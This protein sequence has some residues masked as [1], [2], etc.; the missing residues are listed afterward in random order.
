MSKK[1]IILITILILIIIL[2]L[3][4][5]YLTKNN[6]I[7]NQNT[8]NT[9][10]NFFADIFNFG[11]KTNLNQSNPINNLIDFITGNESVDE[12]KKEIKL[13]SKIS[14]LPIAG[15]GIYQK[16]V[17]TEIPDVEPNQI[18]QA[19]IQE[20][21]S[22]PNTE[23]ISVLKYA[24]KENG[25]IYQTYI[26][27]FE[28]KIYSNT[29]IPNP[30][31]T[32][33]TKYNVIYRY[34]KNKNT[35]VTFLGDLPKETLGQDSNN[36]EIFGSFLQDGVKEISISKDGEKIFYLS[37]TK[38]GVSGVIINNKNE[39]NVIFNSSFSEWNSYWPNNDF[40]VLNTRASGLVDGFAY[41]LNIK[42]S[43]FNK[44]LGD[45]KGLTTLIN[46]DLN[47]IL[48][49][50]NNLSMKILNINNNEVKNLRLRTHTEKCVWSNDNV[51]L[52]C[53]IPKE[54]QTGLIYPD[55]WY[56]GEVSYNDEI[57]KINTETGART[58]I[59]DPNTLY[60]NENIDAINLSLDKDEKTLFF[61]NKAD[62]YLW[63]LKLN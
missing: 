2:F 46:K 62:S 59:I 33:F 10:Q 53:A 23:I 19:T 11:N 55:A 58:K 12:N 14:T 61:M 28:E 24:D 15:Y 44:I 56:Q 7:N 60:E 43:E 52:Y 22:T 16:E 35:I 36:N 30:Y 26:S 37:K 20:T 51:T 42:N 41:I 8:E 5:S 6:N 45:I 50:D 18:Q 34:L 54:I 38:N 1:F 48:Y 63:G 40:V 27:N 39:K 17:Y 4:F 57:W 31:E 29:L 25:N 47:T 13:L 32:L 21:P 9:N 3:G 49:T